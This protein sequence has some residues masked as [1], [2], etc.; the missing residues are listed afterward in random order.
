[1]QAEAPAPR[2][3]VRMETL[4]KGTAVRV[5]VANP[6][7]EWE[8]WSLYRFFRRAEEHEMIDELCRI[9]QAWTELGSLG[10]ISWLP[11]AWA[12]R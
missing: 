8:N 6:D 7:P 9:M 12:V 11:D 5:Q 4:G 3:E 10:L 1:M 2:M